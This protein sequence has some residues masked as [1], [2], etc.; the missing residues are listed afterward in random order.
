MES[1]SHVGTD[2]KLGRSKVSIDLP[3]HSAYLAS[4]DFI[5]KDDPTMLVF[6]SRMEEPLTKPVVSP[7]KHVLLGL[8]SYV[9]FALLHHV[10][11]I[12]F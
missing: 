7:G 3:A 5:T 9:S 12:E 8:G 4:I 6:S 2:K 10:E 11:R 1:A